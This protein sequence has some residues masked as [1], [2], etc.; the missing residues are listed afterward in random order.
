M[1]AHRGRGHRY[2]FGWRSPSFSGRLGACHALELPFVFGTL[3]AASG[4][5][6]LLGQDPPRELS[7]AMIAAWTDYA[8]TGDPGWAAGS[9]HR[10]V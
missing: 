4:P 2:E 1:A 7:A 9:V 6:A 8:R 10:F 3:D 5:D